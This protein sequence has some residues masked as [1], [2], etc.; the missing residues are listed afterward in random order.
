MSFITDTIQGALVALLVVICS[1]GVGFTAK[2]DTSKIG[3]S[4]LLQPSLLGYQLAYIL[5]IGI[6]CSNM[7]IS[8]FWMRAFASKTDTDLWL[9]CG[10]A[11]LAV[12]LILG[13]VGSTGYIA[14]WA[15]VWTPDLYG[16]LAFF[17]LMERLPSWV[18]GFV[19]VMA[20][21]LSCAGRIQPPL[22]GQGEAKKA[23]YAS[24]R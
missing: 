7:F 8:G 19:T 1:F 3:D 2:I 22:M 11:S 24:I 4:G 15:G 20:V 16:G 13:L 9:G 21:V 17:L 12:F 23:D 6:L 18:V 10:I 14:A 5:L